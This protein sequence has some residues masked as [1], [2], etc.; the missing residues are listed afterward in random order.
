M[1][2]YWVYILSSLN[3]TLYV[4]VTNNME[5]RVQQHKSR[6]VPGFTARYNVTRLVHS[7]VFSDVRDAIARE[8][9]IKSWSR[10]RKSRLIEEHNP[11]WDDLASSFDR[12]D[13]RGR[14]A[15][16]Q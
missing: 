4:G 12:P 8:K 11:G 14:C 9:Q 13:C 5:R 6:Q 15:P 10:V 3:R 16:S 1:P 2:Q 7:E